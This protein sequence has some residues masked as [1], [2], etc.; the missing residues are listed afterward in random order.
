M[1]ETS[2]H[3][4]CSWIMKYSDAD[5]DGPINAWDIQQNS[6][7]KPRKSENWFT[8]LVFHRNHQPLQPMSPHSWYWPSHLPMSEDFLFQPRSLQLTKF[9]QDRTFK[10]VNSSFYLKMLILPVIWGRDTQ[11]LRCCTTHMSYEDRTCCKNPPSRRRMH[12]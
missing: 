5:R 11:G 4:T 2:R 12:D 10:I 6:S 8:H 1:P 3:L 9:H 7:F